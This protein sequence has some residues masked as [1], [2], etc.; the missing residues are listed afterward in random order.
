M[1]DYI[2]TDWA[3]DKEVQDWAESIF[4]EFKEENGGD[5]FDAESFRDEMLERAWEYADSSQHVIYTYRAIQIC[6]N[7]NTDSGEERLAD[8]YGKPFEGCESFADVCTRLAFAELL[9]R[10]E[11]A[12]CD[13]IDNWTPKE[14]E[15]DEEESEE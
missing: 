5:A 1:S 13:L 4:S 10:I 12:L 15:E 2:K 9:S 6:G 7:C 3:L 11:T 14:E 8:I